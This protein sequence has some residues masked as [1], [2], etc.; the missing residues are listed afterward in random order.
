M[1]QLW[2]YANTVLCFIEHS[3]LDS[4]KPILFLRYVD[5]IFATSICK[6]FYTLFKTQCPD[7]QLESVTIDT[8][9]YL[10]RSTF[11]NPHSII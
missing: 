3:I 10:S 7:V 9:G 4:Y 6:E 11:S 2:V 8:K 1:V 5:N